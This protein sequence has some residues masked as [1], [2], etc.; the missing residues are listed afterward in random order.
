ML[1]RKRTIAFLMAA[2][3][4]LNWHLTSQAAVSQPDNLN[5]GTGKVLSEGNEKDIMQKEFSKEKLQELDDFINK[6]VE[7]GFPGAV[8]TVIKDGKV[9]KNSAY[10][11][12]KKWDKNNLMSK[13]EK[14]TVDTLFDVASITKMMSTN[15]AL[16]RLVSQG[17]LDL[18]APVSKYIPEFKDSAEDPIKGKSKITVRNVLNHTAGFAP[19][20]RFFDNNSAGKF[21]SQDRNTTL[22]LL[23]K[24]PLAYV[25]GTKVVYSDTDYML[26]GLI[27][28]KITGM[29]QDEYVEKEIYKPLGLK[30]T[31]YNPLKKGFKPE[32]AA[33]TERNGN[34][35]DYS[36]PLFNNIR[37][38][39]LQ[40]EVHDEKAWYSMGGVSGHAGLFSTTGDLAVLSQLILNGG[41]YGDVNIFSRDVLSEFTKPADKNIT[42]GLG[43]DRQGDGKKTWEFGPYA[44][45]LTIG[46]TG[47][48]GCVVN[49]DPLNNMAVILLTNMRHSPTVL[50][51]FEGSKWETGRY[52]SIM[53]KVYEAFMENRDTVKKDRSKAITNTAEGNASQ[54]SMKFPEDD[55]TSRVYAR[56]RGVFKGYRG[57]GSIRVENHGAETADLYINGKKIDISSALKSH[58]GAASFDIS[59]LVVT[60]QNSLKVLNVKPE[61]SFVNVSVHYPQVV[62]GNPKEAGFKENSFLNKEKIFN[63]T[64]KGVKSSSLTIVKNGKLIMQWSND[65]NPN[66][67]ASLDEVIPKLTANIALEKLVSEGTLD[68]D[69]PLGNLIPEGTSINKNT[70]TLRQLLSSEKP[71]YG[72]LIRII[73]KAAGLSFKEYA[74]QNIYNPLGITDKTSKETALA[75]MGQSLLNRGGYGGIRLF[76][77]ETSD[78]FVKPLNNNPSRGLG[79]ERKITNYMSYGVTEADGTKIII[80]P[81][82]DMAVIIKIP[83]INDSNNNLYKDIVKK[84]YELL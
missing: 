26:L 29:R 1:K 81:I 37:E 49:I 77:G 56:S 27:I 76:N 63:Q 30:N 64:L 54:T 36:I 46:H 6:E 11:Y 42:Y 79:Y 7:E 41:T 47:W 12:K 39:T 21:Y 80:D 28:E 4:T 35:R 8:L 52:G 25:P 34:T 18:D 23:P 9:V 78:Q 71:D 15:L 31:M 82:H 40:G 65:K 58:Q 53:S 17:K 24:A 5:N 55:P 72:L 19:E 57:R 68:L 61:G 70:A 67:E 22:E 14:M 69:K 62:K 75:V 60:G 44:S 45:Y 74:L 20:I 32:D 16:Q 84:I 3:L 73:E 59:T 51:N 66:N 2:A 48:T 13:P 43:W 50:N 33:A 83:Q 38:Y 10:G